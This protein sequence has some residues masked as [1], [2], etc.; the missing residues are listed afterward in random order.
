MAKK[1]F[2]K[3]DFLKYENK[4]G[5]FVIFEGIDLMPTYQYTKKLSVAAHFDPSKYCENENGV[6][7]GTR[8]FLEVAKSNKPCEKTIDTFEEDY[9]WKICTEAEKAAAIEKL[10]AYGY[11]WD[12]ETL[13]IIDIETGEIVHKIIVPKLEYNGDIIKPMCNEFKD[14]LKDFVISKNKFCSSGCGYNQYM[15]DNEYWD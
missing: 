7:W 1:I 14:L 5:S 4:P 2:N 10:R 6:G 13:S 8:P 11:E 12:D 3:G 15:Y 9:F